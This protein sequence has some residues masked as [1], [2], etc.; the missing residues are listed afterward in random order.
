MGP[1]LSMLQLNAIAPC[2]L[3]RPYVGRNPVTPTRSQGE[4]IEP[5]VSDPMAKAKSPAATPAAE[6]ADEPLDP[7]SRFHG[8]RVRPPNQVSPIA[9]SPSVVFATRTAPASSNRL[10]TVALKSKT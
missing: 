10:M 5:Y 6:P 4:T 3:T 8:L 9:S 7:C 2:R 1:S